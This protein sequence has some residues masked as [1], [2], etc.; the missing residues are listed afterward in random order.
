MRTLLG[1][2]VHLFPVRFRE[3]FGPELIDQIAI[4]HDRAIA[5][6]FRAEVVFFVTTALDLVRSA[7]AEHGQPTW[8]QGRPATKGS[9]GGDMGLRIWINDL[10][11]AARALRRAPGFTVVTVLT[12]GIAL[13]ANAGIFT[14]VNTVLLDPLPF[15]NADRLVYI[16]A[17]AP[18]SD[19][20]DEFP[21]ANEFYVQYREESQF[22]EDL[23]TFNSFTNTMRTEDRVER[24][25]MAAPTVSLFST[26]GVEPILGRLPT[27][28]EAQEVAL[29]SHGLWTTW[30]GADPS[31]L[32]RSYEIGGSTRR[33]IGVMAADFWFPEERVQAWIPTRIIAAEVRP[34]RFGT[35]LVGRVAPGT[36]L[37][38]LNAELQRLAMRIPERFGAPPNYVRFMEQHRPV[39]RPL[40]EELLGDSSGPLW[41]LIGAVGIVLLIACANVANLLGVRAERRQQEFAVRRALGAGARPLVRLQMAEVFVLATL[42]AT[43]AMA[44]AY[45]GVPAFLQ[46]AP[47]GVPRLNDASVSGT[48][49]VF[50]ALL[51]L[52]AALV[53]GLAPSVAASRPRLGRLRDGSRGTTRRTHWG[54]DG[55]VVAQTALALVLLIGSGLLLQSFQQLRTVDPGYETED[56]FTFQI[57]PEAEHLVDGPTWAAFHMSFLERLRGLPGVELAGIIENVPLNEGVWTPRFQ[58]EATAGDPEAG[59]LLGHTFSGGDYFEAMGIEVLQGRAFTDRDHTSELGN[60]VVSKAAA[61]LLW[62][63]ENPLGQVIQRPDL[64]SWETVVGVVEDVHQNDFR[65]AP[66]PMVYFPMTGQTPTDWALSSPGYVLK[67]ERADVIAS[68]VRDLVR[69]VAPSAPMYRIFTMQTLAEDS[70]ATL[71]FTALT[72][73]TAATIAL[74]LGALGLYGVL[75]YLV[76]ERTQEIGVRMALGARVEQ[77]RR[78]VVVQGVRVVGLGIVLGALAALGVM[79]A[80]GSL[81]FGVDAVEPVTYVVMSAAM[82]AIGLLASY[83]PARRA[84]GVDPVQSMRGS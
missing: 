51:A 71:T 54:R 34:G 48:T 50:T 53:C 84:S 6:G 29:I 75:S 17:S 47:E 22:L 7:I 58:T 65:G 35:E 5:T 52:A 32:G 19:F 39:V 56:L 70:M 13:G 14:V 46:V 57:A 18:G 43:L 33:I 2:M 27:D 15:P 81:L 31:V 3:E 67:T 80:L 83:V 38:A 25:A 12:L 20:P 9:G 45:V 42:S 11:L 21:A 49:L 30:F 36:D 4:D 44:I 69:E 73:G 64:D 24:I 23:G 41:V 59:V 55:L 10:K 62:P 76:A 74:L 28:E 61:D 16:A 82:M 77:V 66:D 78:M 63:G 68:E 8:T 26:L 40:S 37:D 79:R 60:A 72:L 1:L